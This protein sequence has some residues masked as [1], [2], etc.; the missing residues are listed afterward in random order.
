MINKFEEET[1]DTPNKYDYVDLYI[2]SMR[3]AGFGVHM[4]DDFLLNAIDH[5]QFTHLFSNFDDRRINYWFY[6]LHNAY[7]SEN[8]FVIQRAKKRV[9]KQFNSKVIKSDKI[10]YYGSSVI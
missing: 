6:I 7:L 10:R 5:P 4:R 2:G 1:G 8:N 3:N 9:V